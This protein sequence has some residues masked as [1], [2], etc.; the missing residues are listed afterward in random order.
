MLAPHSIRRLG[1]EDIRGFAPV[2]AALFLDA[3]QEGASIGFM[4]DLTL[5]RATR[6]WCDVADAPQGRVVLA[7]EDAAG[8]AGVVIVAPMPGETQPHRAEIA[9][10]VVHRRARGRGLGTALMRAAEDEAR[11]MGKSLATLFTR[12]GSD[13]ERLYRRLGW[14]KA[15]VIPDDSRKPDGTLCDGAVFYKRVGR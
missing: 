1:T 13:A 14:L 12:S 11:A 8:I 15:G 10:M 4:D 9:K 3:V 6:Y 7:G 2:L 5:E